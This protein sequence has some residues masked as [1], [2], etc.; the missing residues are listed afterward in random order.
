MNIEE[1]DFGKDYQLTVRIKNPSGEDEKP[2][3]INFTAEKRR[4]RFIAHLINFKID[5]PGQLLFEL[6]LN[7]EHLASHTVDI[8]KAELNS[9]NT[10]D[11]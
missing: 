11:S 1:D 5:G 3:R 2:N 4:Q 6:V 10:Q 7:G 9:D 8:I